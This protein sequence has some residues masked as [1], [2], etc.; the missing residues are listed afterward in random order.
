MKSGMKQIANKLLIIAT[1]EPLLRWRTTPT[2]PSI[3]R[4]REPSTAP[5][6]NSIG[7]TRAP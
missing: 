6:R 1:P 4:D 3:W 2:R 7:P 5:S